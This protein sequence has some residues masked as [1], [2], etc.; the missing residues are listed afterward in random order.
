MTRTTRLLLRAASAQTLSLLLLASSACAGGSATPP[1][2]AQ[3]IDSANAAPA[4]VASDTLA[5]KLDAVF[6]APKFSSA[7]WGVRVETLDG[8]VLYDRNGEK[9]FMPASNLKII[10]TSAAL[11]K[12]GPDFTYRTT[13]EVVGEVLADGT[14]KGDLLITGSGDPSLGAWHPDNKQNSTTLFADW[15]EQLRAAGITRIDGNIVS[16]GRCFT[17]EGICTE[18][19]YWD[20][21][22]WYAAESSGLAMEENAFRCKIKP[23]TNVGDPARIEIIPAT[24]YVTVVNDVRTVEA[25]GTSNADVV[26][27]ADLGNTVRFDR[28]I[29]LDKEVI[30]ERGSIHDG[31]RYAA[32]LLREELERQGLAVSG[33]AYNIRT[34]PGAASLDAAANRRLLIDHVSPPMSALCDVVN[35]VSHNF[36]ADQIVRTL[37]YKLG[38]AGSFKEGTRITREWLKEIGTP[39]ADVVEMQDGS[40]LAYTNIVQPR[41]FTH[42]LRY[43]RTKSPVGSAFYDTLDV[44]NESENR[45]R[46]KTGYISSVRT[47]SGYAITDDGEEI[48]FSMMCNLYGVPTREVS[49]AQ[50]KAWKILMNAKVD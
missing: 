1:V 43:M 44:Q 18:W 12:L 20:L 6:L 21:P 9:G 30:N 40:G 41:Q 27:R 15:I 23:G 29:A 19:V 46:T 36:F 14:L 39:Q 24:D 28:T 16:D 2:A 47:L 38:E 8:R 48:V 49:A 26:W 50:A 31:P 25:G 10:T 42:V 32:Y 33:E 45:V 17:D 7:H 13:V 4:A 3:A 11:E 22:Y 37:G 35:D 34:Y 5:A